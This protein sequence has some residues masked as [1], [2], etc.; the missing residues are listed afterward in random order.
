M[1][2]VPVTSD[3]SSQTL[4]G[5][6]T[7]APAPENVLMAMAEMHR[8]GRLLAPMPKGAKGRKNLITSHRSDG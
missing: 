4:G 3:P 2:T 8:Q 1:P 5:A 7:E 6:G